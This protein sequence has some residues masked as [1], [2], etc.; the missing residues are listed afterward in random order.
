M[1]N[2]FDQFDT[3]AP[4]RGGN[5]FDQFDVPA[6]SASA[7]PPKAAPQR[8][9]MGAGE[10]ALRGAE[11]GITLGFGDEARGAMAAS[12]FDETAPSWV[13]DSIV[14]YSPLV[15]AG[16]LA[17]GVQNL[18]MGKQDARQRYDAAAEEN[19]ALQRQAVE[20]QPGAMA[21]GE[22]GGALAGVAATPMLTPFRAAQ[23]AGLLARGAAAAGNLAATGAAYGGAAGLGAGE[24]DLV[25]RLP[26]AASGAATGAVLAPVIGGAVHGVAGAGR[27]VA[28]QARAVTSPGALADRVV[29]RALQRDGADLPAIAAEMEAARASGQPYALADAAGVNTRGVAGNVARL[30]GEGRTPAREFLEARQIGSETM[31]SQADRIGDR[32]GSL[33]GDRGSIE[34]AGEIISRRSAQAGPAYERAHAVGLNY[35]SEEGQK[36]LS[37]LDRIPNAARAEANNI[38]RISDREG[39]QMIWQPDAQGG[40]SLAVVPNSRQFDYIKRGLDTMIDRNTDSATGRTNTLGSALVGLKKDI[41]SSLDRLNPAYAAAR[42][43]F[44]GEGELL[45][46]LRQG[47]K[48]FHPSTTTEALR[49]TVGEMS[50]GEMD[51]FRLGAANALRQRLSNAPDGTDKVRLAYGSPALREKI[52]WLVPDN[53]ARQQFHEFIRREA[54]MTKT[55]RV[56]G[57]SPTAE[58]LA[59]EADTG[60]TLAEMT[61]A[62]VQAGGGHL[63]SAIRT[64]FTAM[65]QVHPEMRGRVMAEAR[66]VLYDPNPETVRA[67]MTRLDEVEMKA[68][69]RSRV[70]SAVSNALPR[71]LQMSMQ[72]Q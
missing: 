28:D 30:P 39:S 53:A 68:G 45:D 59:D 29:T 18:V 33:M 52:R 16:R 66:R 6:S 69:T 38:L 21:A 54:G 71:G 31:P 14:R 34:T 56:T 9:K 50:L 63:S 42:K 47:Q 3:P 4:L 17:E 35:G 44:A 48:A 13:K 37:L 55:N 43:Q 20:D 22:I 61:K 49:K 25:D 40:F 12:S 24:G 72:G 60:G 19:R 32:I 11:K 5:P 36:L 1:A 27:M 65:K 2:P 46:A 41:L 26:S 62:A 57:G 64:A 15:A 58:R 67:F 7:R 23:G 51:M 10:A 70:L 8:E